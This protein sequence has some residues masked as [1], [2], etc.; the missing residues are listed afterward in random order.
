M[1]YSGLNLRVELLKIFSI[2]MDISRV[3]STNEFIDPLVVGV[4]KSLENLL[5]KLSIRKSLF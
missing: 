4:L 3:E 5:F 2:S 1:I